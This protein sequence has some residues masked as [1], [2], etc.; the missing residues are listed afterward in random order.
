MFDGVHRGHLHLIEVLAFLHQHQRPQKL[1]HGAK[2]IEATVSD[3]RWAH[4]LAHKVLRHSLDEVSRWAR[5]L[6]TFFETRTPSWITKRELREGL[7]WPD[8]RTRE[9]LDELVELEF[10]EVQRGA[11]N[12]YSF[13]L[14][15]TSGNSRAAMTLLHPDELDGL[16]P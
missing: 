6:L 3:Y 15:G 11:N 7:D 10:L 2:Y 9:A 16:W 13:Q 14:A 12:Q 5:E 4:F 1:H 8:R